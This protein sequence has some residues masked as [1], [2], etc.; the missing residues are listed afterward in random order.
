MG[1]LYAPGLYSIVAFAFIFIS[2]LP[3]LIASHYDRELPCRNY[4][5]I[6]LIIYWSCMAIGVLNLNVIAKS[7]GYEFID[8]FSFDG[9]IAIAAKSTAIRYIENT[10]A[11]S[12]SPILLAVSLWL[13]FRVALKSSDTK[14]YII[15]FSFIPVL[16]YTV[17][18][19]EKWPTFL[20]GVFYFSGVF[21]SHD[22]KSCIRLVSSKVKYIFL[23]LALMLISLSLRGANDDSPLHSLQIMFHYVF[24]SYYGLGYWL[25][26]FASEVELSLGSLTFIGPLSYISD[27]VRPAGVYPNSYYVYGNVSNIYTAF[28]YVI[29]DFSMFGVFMLNVVL[30]MF[31]IIAIKA[32]YN[33]FAN[34]TKVWLVF[35]ALMSANVTTFVHNS[36][37]LA[38]VLSI[39]FFILPTISF[40][41]KK[42]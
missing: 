27:N 40:K 26:S 11:N 33:T 9:V 19:T 10:T 20:S 36:V 25:V 42:L 23:V 7:T 1:V 24:A 2:C 38:I 17:L 29:Q 39:L 12:G 16:L 37:F 32:K 35:S 21:S 5:Q 30:S 22:F 13:I 14:A 6:N 28:R 3:L 15:F 18:T 34:I 4:P 31:Y 8:I 41:P